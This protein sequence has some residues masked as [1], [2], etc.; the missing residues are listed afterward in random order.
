MRGEGDVPE[1]VHLFF[2]TLFGGR[3]RD[4]EAVKQRASSASE[5]ALFIVHN[6]QL[7][8]KKHIVLGG[9]VHSIT[10]SRKLM[11]VLNRL[12]HCISYSKYEELET[13]LAVAIQ[14]RHA[15]SPKGAKCGPVM[16]TAFDNYD[17]RV[18]TLSGF[19]SLHDTMGIFYQVIDPLATDVDALQQP[20]PCQTE[21]ALPTKKTH[22]RKLTVLPA[23]IAP[24]R[25]KPRMTHFQYAN[26]E[27]SKLPDISGRAR[28]L[29]TLFLVRHYTSNTVPMWTGFNTRLHRDSLPKQ[30]V[31]YMPNL[32]QPITKNEVV[33]DTMRTSM[34]CA[35]ECGQMYGLVTYDLDVAKTAHRIQVTSHPE[36]DDVF[37]MFGVFHIFM[38]YF[39]AI[40]KVIAESGGPAMLT[41]S[42]VLAPGSLRGFIECL[43]YNRCKRL[44]PML[45]LALETL[46]FRRFMHGYENADLVLIELKNAPLENKDDADSICNLAVFRGLFEAFEEFKMSVEN[47]RLGRTAQFWA[48]Y[49]RYIHIY[50]I[51]ERAV[52]ETDIDLFITMLTPITDL[53][54]ATNRQNYARWM[55]KYQLDLMNLDDSHPGLR[56]LLENGG[57]SIRR[58]N[59]EFSRIPVDLTLE[60]TVNAD[61]ASR[62]TG[63]T[64]STNNYSSRVR[65]SVTKSSRAAIVNE[66]LTMVGMGNSRDIK[67]ELSP[68]RI[69]K[70]NED[71]QKVVKQ[72]EDSINPFALDP[73]LPLINIST[74][75]SVPVETSTS[76]LGIPEEGKTRHENFVSECI[77]NEE[78]FEKPIRKNPLRTF[79][80][81]CVANRKANK[82]SKEA[83]LK[84]TSAL[85]GR[86]AF[87]AATSNIDLE[88]IFSFPLTPVPLSMC[89]SDG[90][91]AHTDKSKLS[92]LLEDVVKDHGSPS[93]V[94][95][96]IIDGNF[97][98]HC[99]SPDQ[100]ATYGELSRNI[101]AASLSYT[102]RRI[103][104]TF[105]TYERPSIKD[106]ERERRDAVM[107]GDLII[108]GPEQRR[109]ASFKKQLERESFKQQLPVFLT[110]DWSN[111]HYSP[112]LNEREV[113]L[114][115][116]GECTRYF[117][118]DG[119]VCAESVPSL[120]CNHAEAD[121]RVIL[122]M[123]EADRST[124][125]DI[126]VRASDTDILVL[127]LH[128]VHRVSST[129]WME[130]GTRGQGNLRYINVT[131]IA[132][133]IGP[134]MCAAL[135]GLHAFTGCDYTSAFV[136]KGKNRPYNIVAKS[137]K[138]QDAFASLSHAVPT[139]EVVKSLHDFVCV[140]YGARKVVPLNKYRFSVV[141][142]TYRQKSNARH[143]FEKL[144]S[145]EGSTIPPCEREL[146]PHID[147]SGFVARLWGN[148]HHQII[149]KTPTSGWEKSN[150]QFQ[151]VWFDG[152]Q[153]PPTLIPEVPTEP[154][155]DGGEYADEDQDPPLQ[156]LESSDEESEPE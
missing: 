73:S 96:H 80:S 29:D 28:K 77:A 106:I 94:G 107:N 7:M 143:P 24:Y 23:E 70:D 124:A 145:I 85:L 20:A 45:A 15:S 65:W 86:I 83:Q 19:E 79:A 44:H 153:M 123:I 21:N 43:N 112:L 26:A 40:G 60:Q 103:E 50:H 92:K 12:G 35:K 116:M 129:V 102:S 144:K 150:N 72:I 151:I 8:P 126:V 69:K 67:A 110:K 117:V 17:E 14:S 68:A 142:K 27:Y 131:K 138:F 16:G 101:L 120:R 78:R 141:D 90:V 4:S 37:I 66:A 155:E 33:A 122:H 75:K 34:K 18:H 58:S 30:V 121:T 63:Y 13:E 31:H 46:L 57:F 11:T 113:Y 6:G 38:C 49:I 48:M 36:F 82:N 135:P 10:G 42:G 56:H 140:L 52:R 114:G 132:N 53:C 156:E 91:M 136:R 93:F 128:H 111:S 105:D 100:P 152:E 61:A 39:R 76:L 54:F 133:S 130:V 97:Q 32:N 55:S 125:G 109:D 51:V 74:G 108:E 87:T 84:C 2:Q 3:N 146:A 22:K 99:L 115:V 59:N 41:E 154:I 1:L 95:T 62:L 81:N 71:L 149:E 64:S 47:G 9:L 119:E 104:V 147:R 137:E 88:Y 25:K 127:L 118:Q 98:L 89:N 148:A 5:D 139:D 134:A